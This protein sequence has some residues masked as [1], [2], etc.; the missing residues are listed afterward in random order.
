MSATT[1]RHT[2][3]SNGNSNGGKQQLAKI[4][5]DVA[6]LGLC[7]VASFYIS[8]YIRES[9]DPTNISRSSANVRQIQDRLA[10]LLSDRSIDEGDD[11]EGEE[12]GGTSTKE[13]KKPIELSEHEMV[14]ASDNVIDPKDI[15]V[16]F[17]DVG[18]IDDIKAEIWDLIVLPLQRPDLFRSESGLVTPPKG[19]LLYGQPGTGKTMLA[20]AIAK[21]SGAAFINVRLSTILSKWFGESNKTIA[22]IFSLAEKLSPSIIFIDELDTFLGQRDGHDHATVGS[23]KSEFLT[24]WD[25][26]TTGNLDSKPVMVLG[27]TNHP[28]NVDAAILRRLPRSFE[29]GLP[30]MKSRLAILELMLRKQSMTEEARDLLPAVAKQTEGFSGSDLKELCRFAAME[31]IRELTYESSQSAVQGTSEID[32]DDV[33]GPAKGVKIRPVSSKDFAKAVK[34]VKRTG[35]SATEFYNKKHGSSKS[36]RRINDLPIGGVDM[37]ELVKGVALLRQL[38]DESSSSP[39]DDDFDDIPNISD[40][41]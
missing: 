23:I 17:S 11:D 8:K 33:V 6:Y 37:K 16:R 39:D 28:Y 14:V 7:C 3:D 24:L 19:I 21:E 22:A 36:S 12:K 34:N 30:P 10:R 29:I 1:S 35:E 13:Q 9:M 32:K 5:F 15:M 25:G 40:G 26:M 18:G 38:M 31:P 2:N 20:K 41:I 27:A 4:V